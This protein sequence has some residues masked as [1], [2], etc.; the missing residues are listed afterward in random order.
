MI[1]TASTA[2]SALGRFWGFDPVGATRCTDGV[3]FGVK[4][5]TGRFN[6]RGLVT[7]KFSAPLAAKLCVRPK[8][9]RGAR[10]CSRSSITM[11]SSK[12]VAFLLVC[13]SVYV[14]IY[15]YIYIYMPSVL[16]RCWLGGRKGGADLHIAQLMPL[17]LTVSCSSK[18]QIGFTVLVP[19]Y[20]GC[21]GKEAVKWL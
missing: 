19:A 11:P 20:P 4:E 12:N 5:S 9:Y 6:L 21:P 17:P 14:Y 1:I 8:R 13:P 16:W 15:I 2:R 18:I 7:P 10:M 3:V